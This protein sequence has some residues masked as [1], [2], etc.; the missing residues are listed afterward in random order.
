[1]TSNAKSFT[2]LYFA[3]LREQSG[4]DR[5]TLSSAATTPAELYAELCRRHAFDLTEE[6]LRP[7]VNHA[8]C[9][10][11]QHLNDGDTVAFIPPVSGG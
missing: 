5:E 9:D 4:C 1:M 3:A 11:R 6:R 7:A 8:F 2:V 10:W